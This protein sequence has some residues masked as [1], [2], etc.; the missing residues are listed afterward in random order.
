MRDRRW[1]R[2]LSLAVAC[3]AA[4]LVWVVPANAQLPPP[5]PAAAPAPSFPA[6]W[7][8]VT[9]RANLYAG[10]EANATI[11][12]EVPAGAILQVVSAP[13][14]RAR[15]LN[16]LTNGLAWI[17]PAAAERIDDPTPEEIAAIANFEPWWA[18]THRPAPAWSTEAADAERFGTI[19]MWRYLQVVSPQYGS[20]V[21]TVD[22][23]NSAQ[24]FVD[25]LNIG[26]VGEPPPEYFE[27]PPPDEEVIDLPGRIVRETDWFERPVLADYFSVERFP[28]NTPV[29]V[30]GAVTQDDTS[31]YRIGR[32]EYVPSRAVRIPS[33]PDRTFPGRWIDA[34]ISEPVMLTAYE[35]AR[36]VYS[37]LAVK[38]R[39][40]FETP[41]GIFRIWRRVANETMDSLTLGIP[42]ESREGYYLKDVLFTQ[43]FT[44]DGAALHYNYWR[45]N[46]GSAGSH[47]CLGMNYDDSLFFWEFA[48]VG[49]PVYIH[50]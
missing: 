27:N 10:P 21:L 36:P 23:R 17:D 43:Y 35:D 19:P 44:G 39:T 40:A 1:R 18:M 11:F 12:G 34:N 9:S 4:T 14:V 42:R 25:A 37:A 7:V 2:L 31:W 28:I 46:W 13:Q 15:V 22:P 20:R 49:T 26:S 33:T 38:G 32:D 29:R 41:T 24:S 48:K 16:P 5:R 8:T 45:S 30:E 3:A 47:G 50:D 6:Y